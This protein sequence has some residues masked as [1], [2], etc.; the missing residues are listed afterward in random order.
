MPDDLA[1]LQ[2]MLTSDFTLITILSRSRGAGL[3][4]VAFAVAV[5]MPVGALPIFPGRPVS[6]RSPDARRR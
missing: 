4:I 5:D 3:A 2:H 1:A 6:A